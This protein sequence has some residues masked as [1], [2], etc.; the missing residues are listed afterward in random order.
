MIMAGSF[1]GTRTTGT[2]S[3]CEIACI[4][5]KR[6]D[7]SFKP[8][9]RSTQ[10]ASKP[11]RAMT[12]AVKLLGTESQPSVTHFPSRQICL[13]LFVRTVVPPVI[14]W[15]RASCAPHQPGRLCDTIQLRPLI[16]GRYAVAGHRRREPALRTEREPLQRNHPRGF[17]DARAELGHGLDARLLRR[18]Q[19]EH[20][21]PVLG[22]GAERLEAARP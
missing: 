5:G 22:D 14:A 10:S 9:C 19:S 13:I 21:D 3:V 20:H 12:S 16:V 7:S 6:L 2:V 18:D 15:R 17:L 1:H 8:C 4:I 11:W